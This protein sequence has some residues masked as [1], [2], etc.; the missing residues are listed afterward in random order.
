MSSSADRKRKRLLEET[1]LEMLRKRKMGASLCPSE[2]ARA[3]Q[4]QNWRPL[5]PAV[6]KAARDLSQQVQSTE[7]A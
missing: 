4:P 5:M 7:D 6:R 2:V 1:T 3:V